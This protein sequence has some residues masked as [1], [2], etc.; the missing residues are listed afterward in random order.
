MLPMTFAF[1]VAFPLALAI[2]SSGVAAAGRDT[3][4]VYVANTLGAIGGALAAGFFLVP[5]LGLRGTFVGMS[6]AGTIGGVMLAAAVLAPRAGGTVRRL[7]VIGALTAGGLLATLVDVPRWDRNLLSSG[8]YKYA[9]YIHPD[10]A[11]DFETS[12][13]AG[14][15]EYYKEGAAATVSVRRLSG[16]LALAIDGK[17]DA[18]NAGDMLTQ[19]LLGVL[20]VLMHADPQDLC[21]IGLGS[22]VTV[23]SALATGLVRR[24][25]VIEISPE[26]VEASVFFSEENGAVLRAPGVHLV[27]GDG[28]SH[29]QLTTRRYDVVVSEPSNPWMA[30]V[31]AL[32]TR[33]FFEA[34]R[35]QLKPDGLLCQWAHTYDMSDSDLRSI[36]RTFGSVFPQG[37]MW[38][39][40]DGDL[41]LIGTAGTD[42]EGRLANIVERGRSGSI[43]AVLADVA[44][45]P[46]AAPFELLS[47]FAGGPAELARYGDGAPIQTDDRMALEF[48]APRAIYGRSTDANSTTIRA[49]TADARLPASV[50]AV[51]HAADARSWTA[52]GTMDMKAQAFL[53]A[54]DSFR[55][56]VAL[57]GRDADALRGASDAAAGANR[58]AEHR[59][60]LEAL[61]AAAPANAALHVELSRVRAAAGD[62]DGAIS[63]ASEAR[64]LEPGDPRPAEQLASV[65]AD[66]GDAARLGPLADALVAR[67]PER[68]DGRYYRATALLLLGRPAEA[69]GE[70]RQLLAAN[71]RYAKAQNLLG[72]A[73]ATSGQR[74]CAQAAF[75]ASIRLNPRE[76][77]SYINLGLIYLQTADPVTAADYFAEALALDPVS[78]AAKNGLRQAHAALATP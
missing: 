68:D 59:T 60:W 3:A 78:A 45:A 61:A 73:C 15:L 11:G 72:A 44:V 75:E 25:D 36:V 9:P 46:A 35:A 22:G 24:A 40:G 28:R 58:Q 39:V 53:T 49:L 14:R 47:L 51:M 66:M 48:T 34:A 41:L 38:R 52:R 71:A 55:R 33:E 64:R 13:R 50:A 67:Y 17:I 37:T 29:L 1:G 27:V 42:I 31:A 77:S 2:G 26:V 10:D 12:L 32:F 65:F 43:A 16:T 54:Y 8:A 63:A 56:A 74:D 23:G 6:R 18:S 20:P 76:A 19:R 7:G 70:A 30:G 62:F 5:Q 69:A 57:D 21:V 4:R